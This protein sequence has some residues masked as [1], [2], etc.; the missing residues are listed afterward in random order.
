MRNLILSLL[1]VLP[2]ALSAQNYYED[3]CNTQEK[4]EQDIEQVKRFNWFGKDFCLFMC[5]VPS[6]EAYKTVYRYVKSAQ[7]YSVE[8]DA[9]EI[10]TNTKIGGRADTSGYLLRATMHNHVAVA[11]GNSPQECIYNLHMLILT[12]QHAMATLLDRDSL[13]TAQK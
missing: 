2:F 1:L 12:G 8:L 5:N 4:I 10:Q 7:L 3:R 9:H 11:W 6:H 13:T